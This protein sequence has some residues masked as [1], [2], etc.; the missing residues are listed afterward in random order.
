MH[1]PGVNPPT[2]A[3]QLGGSNRSDDSALLPVCCVEGAESNVCI[4]IAV[5]SGS[6][7]TGMLVI[8]SLVTQTSSVTGGL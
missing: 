8:C 3:G 2:R 1:T 5:C 7:A 4:E 6:L